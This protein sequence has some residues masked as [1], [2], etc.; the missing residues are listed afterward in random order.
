M[1][2][3]AENSVGKIGAVFQ[4]PVPV[5]CIIYVLIYSAPDIGIGKVVAS[6][7]VSIPRTTTRTTT[8]VVAIRD[9]FR[10]QKQG[11]RR[12]RFRIEESRCDAFQEPARRRFNLIKLA[13]D[14]CW[15]D[16]WLR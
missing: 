9:P 2:I 3:S 6:D 10:V 7:V 5:F 4:S 1:V 14:L 11:R 8:T 12:R 15:T 16:G 13:H